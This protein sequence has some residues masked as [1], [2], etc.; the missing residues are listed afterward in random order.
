[1]NPFLDSK[2]TQLAFYVVLTSLPSRKTDESRTD[3]GIRERFS[4]LILCALYLELT[5]MQFED[6]EHR[7]TRNDQQQNRDWSACKFPF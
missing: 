4:N 3:A 6:I 7:W 2:K 5:Q 1:V